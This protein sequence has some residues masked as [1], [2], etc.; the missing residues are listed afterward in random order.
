[1]GVSEHNQLWMSLG[2]AKQTCVYEDKWVAWLFPWEPVIGD[3]R[4]QGQVELAW[5]QV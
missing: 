4:Y 5:S 3:S 2:K 1:M